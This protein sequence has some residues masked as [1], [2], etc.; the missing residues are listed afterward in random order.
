MDEF[1][2]LL[3]DAM[4]VSGTHSERALSTKLALS[5]NTVSGWRR[6]GIEPSDESIVAVARL[7]NRD[8]APALLAMRA[9]K[10]KT[11]L[12]KSIWLRMKADAVS[13]PSATA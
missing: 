4:R 5:H 7:A 11:D 8:P 10:A 12:A 1:L 3:D 9:H 2:E 6:R 13:Q